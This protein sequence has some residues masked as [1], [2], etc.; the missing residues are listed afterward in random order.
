[1][2]ENNR[3]SFSVLKR[4]IK[5]RKKTIIILVSI[6]LLIS[7]ITAFTNYSF[8]ENT[9]AKNIIP[10]LNINNKKISSQELMFSKAEVKDLTEKLNIMGQIVFLE[11]INISSK[12]MGRLEKLKV[13]E[14]ERVKKGQIIAQIE[15]LPL[16]LTLKQQMAE[17]DIARKSYDLATAKYNNA[18]KAI[19][20]KWKSIKKAKA[21]L[22][23]KKV[24]YLNMNRILKN[25]TELFK[26]G[27]VSESDLESLK[28]QHTTLYTKYELAKSDY[29]IQKVGFRIQDIKCEGL[30]VPKKTKDILKV[31][32]RIN[33]KIERAELEAA[34]ARIR[35]VQKSIESTKIMLKETKIKSPINGLVAAKNMEAGEMVKDDSII[36]TLVNISKVFVAL[37]VNEKDSMKVKLGQNVKFTVDALGKKEMTGTVSRITPVVDMKTRT[38]EI[39]AIVDNDGYKLL[40]GMFA[41]ANVITGIKEKRLTLP[42]SSLIN[43]DGNKAQVYIVKKDIVFK[44][45]VELGEECNMEIEILAGIQKGDTVISR[46]I[47]LVYPGMKIKNSGVNS[48][49]L[50]VSKLETAE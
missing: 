21:D 29:E 34:G 44:Q 30:K 25:K 26:A 45:D 10:D 20:I 35:Q 22:Q 46:G 36:A 18:E 24:S 16:E 37:N 50:S 15:S 9:T 32:K 39:K 48:G 11:K 40:P 17:L 31:I 23:D 28:A 43:K 12:V 33:T 47:N 38:V 8:V 4:A 41:R 2:E 27:A 3:E 19:E 14:G 6:V 7:V 5:N 1:M 42:S 13:N 49:S